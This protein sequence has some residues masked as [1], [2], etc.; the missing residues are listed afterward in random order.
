MDHA[1]SQLVHSPTRLNNILD[2]FITNLPALTKSVDVIPGISD[3]DIVLINSLVRS[4][5]LKQEQN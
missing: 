3:H 1:L 4:P 5:I 2:L